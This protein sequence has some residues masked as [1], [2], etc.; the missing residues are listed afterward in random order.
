MTTK[1]HIYPVEETGEK[2]RH[3]FYDA[4]HMR[5]QM[6]RKMAEGGDPEPQPPVIEVI[7]GKKGKGT[8]PDR[9]DPNYLRTLNAWY[10]RLGDKLVEFVLIDTARLQ[11][12][13]EAR[14][15]QVE[16]FKETYADY[17]VFDKD[18]RVNWLIH[19]GLGSQSDKI[20]SYFMGKARPEEGRILAEMDNFPGEISSNGHS[21]VAAEAIGDND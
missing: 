19:F 21:E 1:I 2:I 5:R 16:E 13:D 20:L 11:E 4:M 8:E 9:Y 12:M 17:F 6:I 18:D 15:K 7:I 14:Q 3:R 10:E